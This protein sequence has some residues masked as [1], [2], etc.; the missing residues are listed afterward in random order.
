MASLLP[1]LIVSGAALVQCLD[2]LAE[3]ALE[4]D[5]INQVNSL[6]AGWTAGRNDKFE[7]MTL[8]QAKALLGTL[9]SP[10]K[11]MMSDNRSEDGYSSGKVPVNFDTRT[12][13]PSCI[14]AV[15]DQGHC[16]GCWAFA[17]TE[18][19]S[20][21]FCIA[22]KG[23]MD[24]I[25]S[26]EDLMSCDVTKYTLGCNGGVPEYAWKYLETTGITT[27]ACVPYIGNKTEACPSSCNGTSTFRKYKAALG[28]TRLLNGGGSVGAVQQDMYAHGPVQ[29]S[30]SVY[31]DFFAYKSGIYRHTP[32]AKFLGK[33]SVK[34]V[35]YGVSA[36]G[37]AYWDVANSWGPTWGNKG[38]F[39]IARGI[40][41][42]GIETEM[43]FGQAL[44]REVIV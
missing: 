19:L 18:V 23:S 35:G 31:Q 38:Y 15:R 27:E 7:S 20:D 41:E 21:R 14:H 9:S 22:S 2:Q 24:V 29:T 3:P 39:R 30:M 25:L 6:G 5:L 40:G 42:S 13:W 1:W 36:D 26:P 17:A 37:I 44:V 28:S 4:D 12:K 10:S 34:F 11:P 43:V 33:H 16:G 8:E 32:T